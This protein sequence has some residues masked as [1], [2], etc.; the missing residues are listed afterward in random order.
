MQANNILLDTH[1]W[2]W[3]M[4]GDPALSSTSQALIEKAHHNGGLFV[5]TISCWEVAMLEQK[6]R[7]ILNK[8]CLDWI[9]TSLHA[10]V[11]LLP[12]TPEVSVESCHLPEYF[13]GDPADRMIIATAR[14]ESLLLMTRDENILKY[15]GQQRVFAVSA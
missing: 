2:I 12:I 5:S 9:N 1:V 15:A 8:S 6:K 10:G 4:N 3:L 7:V 14:I 13:A 11:Q